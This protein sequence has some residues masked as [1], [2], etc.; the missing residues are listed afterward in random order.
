MAEKIIYKRAYF[1]KGKQKIFINKILSRISVEEVSKLCNLSERTIRDW[2]REKFLMNFKALETLCRKT[3]VKIPSNIQ[4]KEPFWYV[5]GNSSLGGIAVYKK[6]GRVGGDPEYR[7]KK[8][9]EWWEKQGKYKKHPMLSMIKPIKKPSFSSDLA[10]FTGIVMGDGGISSYQLN[11]TLNLN[12]D[13]NYGRFVKRLIKKL[14]NV[15]I[16]TYYRKTSACVTYS[17][18]RKRLVDFC[19]NQLGLEKGNKVKQQI[20]IPSW[21]KRKKQ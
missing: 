15:P 20:D 12:E 16:N 7:K 14:F 3:N 13:V 21:I 4:L 6:Y 5:K 17:I 2:R 9:H 8:W 10:E 11:I 19:I 1:P 18:S